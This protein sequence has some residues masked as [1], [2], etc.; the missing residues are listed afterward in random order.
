MSR[1]LAIQT[2]WNMLHGKTSA[3]PDQSLLANGGLGVDT[4]QV[5]ERTMRTMIRLDSYLAGFVRGDQDVD[6]IFNGCLSSA[7]QIVVSLHLTGGI[8]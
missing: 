2:K 3:Q 6:C 5:L 8:A 1:H 4:Q 7:K